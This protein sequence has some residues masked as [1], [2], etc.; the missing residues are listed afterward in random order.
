[1]SHK[2]AIIGAGGFAREVAGYINKSLRGENKLV[3]FVEDEYYDESNES[4]LE[5]YPLSK[6]D[7]E[8][9]AVVVAIGSANTRRRIIES[10]PQNTKYFTYISEEAII[11]D[12]VDI[13]V[14]SIVCPGTILTNNISIGDHC[15]LNL[16]TS[17][18][19][20]CK[21]G[22]YFTT[23]PGARVSGNCIIGD[24][25]YLGTN[26]AIREGVSICDNVI[27]GLNAGVVKNIIKEGTYVGVPAREIKR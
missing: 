26:S 20:D 16:H 24:S 6:F 19:H 21:I 10:L 8:N 12:G 11:G 1:M 3:F 9:Y 14:G 17:I 7:T 15:H 25:V 4:K 27:V 13:G 18:G 2:L 22:K 23:A 5:I